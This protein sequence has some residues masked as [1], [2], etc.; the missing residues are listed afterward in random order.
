MAATWKQLTFVPSSESLDELRAGWSWLVDDSMQPFMASASGDVFYE[1]ADQS[2]HWLDTGQ[3]VL[4]K[5][6]ADKATFLE[7]LRQDA[8]A[9]WLLAPVVDQLL[10]RGHVLSKDQCFGF[11]VM[12]V[13]G[14]AYSPDNMVAMSA[15]SWYG[16]AGYVHSQI[17][18][19]PDGTNIAF[20]FHET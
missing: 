18:D 4:T 6:A 5:I 3:G 12:P 13:L 11:K 7:A 17:K 19:L 1:A 2:I 14:G 15:A 8:G 20:S 16:F 10:E 9:Q